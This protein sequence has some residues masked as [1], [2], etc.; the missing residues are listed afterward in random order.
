MHAD[1]SGVRTREV[2]VRRTRVLLVDDYPDALEM[3]ELYLRTHG[4]EVATADDGLKAVDQAFACDADVIVLDLELPGI[5]GFEA[6]RRLRADPRTAR[7][8]LVAA[9]GYSHRQQLDQARAAGFDSI[10]VKPCDPSVLVAEIE[11]VRLFR[12]TTAIAALPA[13]VDPLTHNR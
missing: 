13:S 4:Y 12:S 6:A 5:T 3:W 8:P 11:R 2:C 1:V 7:T 9:T 10:I